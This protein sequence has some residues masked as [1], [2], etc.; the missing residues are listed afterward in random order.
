MMKLNCIAPLRKCIIIARQ[1][2]I[3]KY[4]FLNIG[5]ESNGMLFYL[6]RAYRVSL[7]GTFYKGF[8]STER[9]ECLGICKHNFVLIPILFL[10]SFDGMKLEL[11]CVCYIWL[12][13]VHFLHYTTIHLTIW[14]WKVSA[15]TSGSLEKT[16][17]GQKWL[18]VSQ[19]DVCG[20]SLIQ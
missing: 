4:N 5:S 3:K 8:V 15:A 6:W 13:G 10:K 11:S 19:L 9:L 20:K 1:M 16:T 12:M 14:R 18:T 7:K 2:T 17:K